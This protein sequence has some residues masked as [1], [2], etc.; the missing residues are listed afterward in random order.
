MVCQDLPVVTSSSFYELR[1]PHFTLRK[2]PCSLTSK[3]GQ[4]RAPAHSGR[5]M[6][7]LGQVHG[8]SSIL[9]GTAWLQS[10]AR[11]HSPSCPVLNPSCALQASTHS[12]AMKLAGLQQEL[13]VDLSSLVMTVGQITTA[14]NRGDCVLG[15][16]DLLQ[17]QTVYGLVRRR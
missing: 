15:P 14:G 7:L 4:L 8:G 9:E 6:P 13:L 3:P 11:W 16:A 2:Q 10:S 12:T 5:A 17:S 1:C